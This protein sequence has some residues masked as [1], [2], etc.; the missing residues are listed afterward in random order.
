MSHELRTPLNAI[1]GFSEIIKTET[2]GPVGS[3]KYRDHAGD[4]HESGRHLLDLMN[5]ILDLSKVESGMQEIHEAEL[6]IGA[7]SDA[8]LRLTGKPAERQGITL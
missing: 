8:V 4:I 5:D 1:I 7:I 2:F 3:L 6:D